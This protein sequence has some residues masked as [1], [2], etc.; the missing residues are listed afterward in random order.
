M[1]AKKSAHGFERELLEGMLSTA[2]KLASG[3]AVPEGLQTALHELAL[4]IQHGWYQ[5]RFNRLA[6]EWKRDT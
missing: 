1:S 5:E 4:A 2:T 6:A 3:E